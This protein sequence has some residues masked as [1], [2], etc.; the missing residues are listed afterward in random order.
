MVH[1]SNNFCFE[2][3]TFEVTDNKNYKYFINTHI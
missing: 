1:N 2:F 3:D